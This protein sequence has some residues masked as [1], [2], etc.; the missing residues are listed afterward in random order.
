MEKHL[1]RAESHISMIPKPRTMVLL[2]LDWRDATHLGL[3]N[4]EKFRPAT[5]HRLGKILLQTLVPQPARGLF[6]GRMHRSMY[7][8]LLNVLEDFQ[9]RERPSNSRTL[10]FAYDQVKVI[11]SVQAYTIQ[12]SL[13]RLTSRM[14]INYVLS[15]LEEAPAA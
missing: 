13:E 15:N 10:S 9:L 4:L 2:H 12:A 14:F 5:F 7:N 6:E 8:T 3:Q 1:N 11:D